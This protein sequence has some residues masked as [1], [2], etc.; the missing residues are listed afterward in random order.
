MF[1]EY[2]VINK[3]VTFKQMQLMYEIVRIAHS[4]MFEP[5]YLTFLGKDNKCEVNTKR[6]IET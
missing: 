6:L 4:I 1:L 2:I 5:V 3:F